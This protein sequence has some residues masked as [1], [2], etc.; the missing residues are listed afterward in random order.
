M[1][2]EPITED[3]VNA[4]GD[5][6]NSSEAISPEDEKEI[7]KN[8]ADSIDALE[9]GDAKRALESLFKT[10][11]DVYS[12]SIEKRVGNQEEAKEFINMIKD[13][14]SKINDNIKYDSNGKPIYESLFRRGGPFVDS[15]GKFKY[16]PNKS[17]FDPLKAKNAMNKFLRSIRS[18]TVNGIRSVFPEFAASVERNGLT[19]QS[20]G[21]PDAP[22]TSFDPQNNLDA[23]SRIADEATSGDQ[24][25]GRIDEYNR[26]AN[27]RSRDMLNKGE[28]DPESYKNRNSSLKYLV[29]ALALLLAIGG[30][31]AFVWFWIW[32]TM[33]N[34]GCH[35]IS[36]SKGDI[37]PVKSKSLCYSQNPN[38]F[39]P[40]ENTYDFVSTNCNCNKVESPK[41]CEKFACTFGTNG[42]QDQDPNLRPFNK[43]CTPGFQCS[44]D[45]H[46]KCPTMYY[47]FQIMDPISGLKNLLAGAANAGNKEGSYWINLIIHAA[48]IIGIILGVLLVLW[49]IYK[50]VA[51]RKPA[52][53]LKIENGS[54]AG[55]VTKFGNRGYLGN[56]SKYSNYAY[57]GRCIAKP[58]RPYVP[59]RFKF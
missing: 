44:N 32:N 21:G 10:N 49:I 40:T 43:D 48:I 56:L 12:K 50:V 47:S 8:I 33:A 42:K 41:N 36:C 9:S 51:N 25:K 17:T 7:D 18:D 31:G 55:T 24:G 54:A 59:P 3:G 34:S 45:D 58:A 23:S 35:L 28:L 57:M 37:F 22:D 4:E 5:S 26:R 52:E 46:S 1:S 15:S 19:R 2:G 39:N 27:A 38:I 13:I 29:Q 53:T 11:L 16:D 14:Q 30:L 20:D 6:G